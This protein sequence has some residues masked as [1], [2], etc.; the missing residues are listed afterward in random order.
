MP[1]YAETRKM[2]WQRWTV[3]IFVGLVGVAGCTAHIPGTTMTTGPTGGTAGG[4]TGGGPPKM[5]N[6]AG[7]SGLCGNG[8]ID[9]GE[10]CDPA[11]TQNTTCSSLGFTGGTLT[12]SS[13]CQLDASNCTGGKVT[14][15]V[16]PSRTTCA[17]PCAVQFD[18]SGTTGLSGA[19][20]VA[21]N[22]SWDFNDPTSPHK[23]TIGFVVGH[24]F[25]NPGTYLVRTH[26][27]DA[28][29][30]AGFASTMI[31]VEAMSGTT[32]YVAANGSDSNSGTD[33][34]HPYK[35]ARAAVTAHGA[36]NNSVLLRRGD[37]FAI[38]TGFSDTKIL[39][40]KGPFLLGA[41]TDPQSPSSAAPILTD[42]ANNASYT[43]AFNILGEDIRLTD[44]HIK[45]QNGVFNAVYVGANFDLIERVEAEG[46]G[47]GAQ[48]GANTVNAENAG[49]L[50]VADCN[51]HDV[52]AYG[53]YASLVTDLSVIGNSIINFTGSTSAPLHGLRVQ[54]GSSS[55]GT[56][57]TSGQ[58]VT[59][60]YVAENT[61][62]AQSGQVFTAALF[63]G[64]NKK[65]V[66]VNN[67][68]DRT[69][70][71]NPTNSGTT[72]HE[73][74]GLVEGN[75]LQN[76]APNAGYQ[77]IT[78]E[79]Q[80][81]MVRNN[82]IV[83]ADIAVVVGAAPNL[84]SNWTDQI[85]VQ[86]NTA[87]LCPPSGVKNSYPANFAWHN[88]ATGSLVLQNNILYECM[89]S[90]STFLMGAGSGAETID[91][92]L[93]YG[94]PNAPG[95]AGVGTGGVTADPL[96]AKM[97]ADSEMAVTSPAAF[98]L[99]PGSPAIGAG[100][101]TTALQDLAGVARPQA[102]WDMGALQSLSTP[103]S[104]DGGTSSH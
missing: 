50:T 35:T 70:G 58:F 99:Q 22:W 48:T 32:Y 17:A 28:S 74:L 10:Q 65:M 40:F 76:P 13:S 84:P 100:T 44:V 4:A 94:V 79:A 91:H 18:A 24:V 59:N 104:S 87:F 42:N 39:S 31:T 103:S 88:A 66:V 93:M 97:P 41:Y 15:A 69:I 47:G 19:D 37:T 56:G 83:N 38:D 11:L 36:A 96:F 6:D 101:P 80:H 85:V 52:T 63:H 1:Y 12:C 29:G 95:N 23:G 7:P 54:G 68:G 77:A 57:G 26:V 16:T 43:S 81:V 8:A 86:N 60:S 55:N 82:L 90:A 49:D 14:V 78:I 27:R 34:A 92:N 33:M 73:S 64:D 67:H 30:A 9:P 75:L 98:A 5:G 61:I 2:M 102:G 89:T 3:V 46:I 62:Q 53:I 51:F 21:A 71:I 45:G 25:D 72:E 20:Y